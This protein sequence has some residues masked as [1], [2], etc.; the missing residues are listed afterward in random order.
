MAE[1]SVRRSLFVVAVLLPAA[2]GVNAQA[3]APLSQIDATVEVAVVKPH[4]AAVMHNN[5]SFQNNRFEL[6]DQPL[7]KLIAFAYS[8]NSRQI[9]GAPGWVEEKH[10][11][12]SGTTNLTANATLPQE[13][14]L[15]RQLL[16]ERFGLQFHREKREMPAYA[17]QVVNGQPRLTAAADPN[18]QPLEWTQGNG[19][20]RTENYRAST[21]TDFVLI[22]QLFMDRPLVDQTGLTGRYDFKLTYTRGDAPD[23]DA[24]TPP[25]QFTA[26]KE[27]LGLK[28]EPVKASVDAFVIDHVEQPTAN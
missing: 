19:S 15:V 1:A 23:A 20:Q 5:F 2:L 22:K 6:E 16:K 10:W 4:P 9:V 11:D 21:M 18:L 28:F 27:Q 3:N 14:Q 26:I 12:M 17:L 24:D 13:Q 25:P 8:L 7:L